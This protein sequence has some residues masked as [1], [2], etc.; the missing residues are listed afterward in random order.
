MTHDQQPRRHVSRRSLLTHGAAAATV[1][2]TGLAAATGTAAASR[3]DHVVPDDYATI[4]AAVDAASAGDTICVEPGTYEEEVTIGTAVTLQGRT[5]PHS[6]NPAHVDGQLTVLSGSDGTTVRRLRIA[7]TET[8]PGGKFPDPAGVLVKASDVVVEHNLI[9]NFNADLSNGGGSFTL[10]GVQVFGDGVSN[11]TIRENVVRDFSSDG[12]PG[13]WPK[14][15]GIAGVKAQAGVDDITVTGNHVVDHHSEGWV[16]GVV[17]TPSGS[18]PGVPADVT[19][20]RNHI[21]G[22]NDG[23]VYDVFAGPNDGRGGAPYPGSAFGIDGTADASEAT[24][25]RNSLLAPNGAES[26][27]QNNTLVAE[28]NWWGSKTGPTHDGNPG[29]GTWAL[30]RGSASIDYT[31]WLVAPAPSNACVGGTERGNGNAG[32]NGPP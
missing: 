13:D 4:Q 19:V 3:C 22:L 23:S 5:A 27:D 18:A 16:W 14:Y 29:G 21:A 2:V 24:V 9:E 31:P 12:V 8:F 7:P 17:L 32:G 20:E 6:G 15:G 30:E 11:V 1:G 10:H 26:K 28:C 25:V